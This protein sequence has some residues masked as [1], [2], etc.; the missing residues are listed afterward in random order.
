MHAASA[1]SAILTEMAGA[2][3][4][5]PPGLMRNLYYPLRKA[6]YVTQAQMRTTNIKE[7]IIE[8]D[9][10]FGIEQEAKE[11]AED[12]DELVEVQTKLLSV[13]SIPLYT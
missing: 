9:P 4:P 2:I 11:K 7:R 8:R 1:N 12:K 10:T 3:I 13:H 6:E 5:I